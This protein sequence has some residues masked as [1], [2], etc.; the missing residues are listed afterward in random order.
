MLHILKIAIS[1][2]I[3]V[4][5]FQISSG[6]KRVK[7]LY[8]FYYSH[9]SSKMLFIFRPSLT[10]LWRVVDVTMTHCG[11][12]VLVHFC[13]GDEEEKTV[14]RRQHFFTYVTVQYFTNLK[15]FRGVVYTIWLSLHI[16]AVKNLFYYYYCRVLL[17]YVK[18]K[19]TANYFICDY[20]KYNTDIFNKKCDFYMDAINKIHNLACKRKIY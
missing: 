1:Y 15:L 11:S 3:I 20:R 10:W 2:F 9:H 14:N 16:F 7:L 4:S 5:T 6:A 13:L 19:L 8:V 12:T 17:Y 18:S